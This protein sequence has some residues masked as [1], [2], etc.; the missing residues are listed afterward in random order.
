MYTD[1]PVQW[2]LAN[3]EN[4][5]ER[6]ECAT[7]FLIAQAKKVRQDMK[8]KAKKAAETARAAA[9]TAVAKRAKRRTV[10]A[11]PASPTPAT[12]RT[13]RAP[14]NPV[15]PPAP[16]TAR[17]SRTPRSPLANR[18]TPDSSS[19]LPSSSP[20]ANRG[21]PTTRKRARFVVHDDDDDDGEVSRSPS[22]P[23]TKR[24]RQVEPQSCG[25][26]H[27]AFPSA[28]LTVTE[29]NLRPMLA[30]TSPP[31]L[32][33]GPTEELHNLAQYPCCSRRLL[34]YG[35]MS[36]WITFPTWNRVEWWNWV[37]RT[38]DHRIRH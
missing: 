12:P 14:R 9:A 23:P 13:R 3:F 16:A 15:A 6:R 34:P 24:Q 32:S 27:P 1:F 19:T 4:S 38:M 25:S 2:A 17:T 28:V 8:S 21:E 7:Q 37:S 31:A 22:R 10:A 5:A 26:T 29:S 30:S 35:M 36:S 11:A 18:P 33:F 20:L